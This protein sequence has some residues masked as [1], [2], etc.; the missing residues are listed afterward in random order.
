MLD[1]LPIILNEEQARIELKDIQSTYRYRYTSQ[2]RIGY[3]TRHLNG[4]LHPN[5]VLLRKPLA[6]REQTST[7]YIEVTVEGLGKVSIVIFWWP[8]DRIDLMYII[9]VDPLWSKQQ[10]CNHFYQ[11]LFWHLCNISR[12]NTIYC[13]TLCLDSHGTVAW[14]YGGGTRVTRAPS[15]R[16]TVTSGRELIGI[17]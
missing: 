12:T 15:T 2:T 17:R 9:H 7:T 16:V 1:R 13:T 4:A 14:R 6:A 10:R 11:S 5:T 8:N 3:F